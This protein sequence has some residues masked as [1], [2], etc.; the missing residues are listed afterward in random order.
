VILVLLVTGQIAAALPAPE[1]TY[2]SPALAELVAKA[3]ASNRNPPAVLRH[4]RARIESELALILR[5]T[6][7]RERVAQVEQIAMSAEWERPRRY[8]LRVVGYRSQSVGVP[9]SALSFARSWTIPYLYGDR[10]TL[11]VEMGSMNDQSRPRAGGGRARSSRE[12]IRAVHPLAADRDLFYRFTGGD[13]VA[14]LRTHDRV[15]PIVRVHVT[16]HFDSTARASRLGAFEGEIDLDATRHQIVR[17]RG[18]FVTSRGSARGGGSALARMPGLVAVAYVELVN[19]EVDG[20]FWL[21]VTQRTEFQAGF[22]PLGP[23]RSVFR[24]MSRFADVRVERSEGPEAALASSADTTPNVKAEGDTIATVDG[25][26]YRRR[27][28]YAPADSVSR[29]GDWLQPIGTATGSVSAGDFDDL[30][31]DA[32]RPNGRPRVDLLPSK[33]DDVFRFNRVEGVYTGTAITVRFRDAAPGLTAR[34]QGGWA[35]HEQTARGGAVLSL[36][37]GMWNTTLRAERQL[38]TTNDFVSPLE[39]SGVGLAALF[40]GV[41]DK[42]YVDRRVLSVGLTRA[43]GSLETAILVADV[44][45]GDDRAEIARLRHGFIAAGTPFRFNRGVAEGRYARGAVSM[46]LHPDVTGVF[47]EPGIG[48]VASYEI[49][50]GD[51]AWERAE[52]ALAARR[53]WRSITLASRVQG[54]VLVGRA[55]PPQTIFELGGEGALPGYGYKEF[56]GDRAAAGGVLASY[57]F[58]VFRRP[59]R[60]VRSLMIPGLAPGIATGVQSGWAELSSSGARRAVAELD[61]TADVSC[62][63]TMFVSCAEP[64]ARPTDGL[65]ATVDARLTFFGGLVGVGV[66]RPVDRAA[67]WRLVFRFGQEY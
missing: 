55:P 45:I 29:F 20:E 30:A 49:A 18:Q 4:Y 58:P 25:A 66:A 8:D 36:Q 31:P 57:A 63:T 5:D 60:L 54:G 61:A 23:V 13:T 9:Y 38:A 15:I 42:D 50:R 64:I 22:A 11:G 14:R 52:L 12:P 21:P 35:W 33:F 67:P 62:G 16:P 3:A 10:L 7:G 37:R 27:L 19:A 2:A 28:S 56:A 32:W 39:G 26:L 40:G 46:E 24:L 17:M 34:V 65:R 47:L 43:V 1:S 53:T 6:L 51:L 48:A 59:I 44:G 41:D